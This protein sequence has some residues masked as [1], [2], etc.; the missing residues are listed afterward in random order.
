[1]LITTVNIFLNSMSDVTHTEFYSGG[2]DFVTDMSL[3]TDFNSYLLGFVGSRYFSPSVVFEGSDCHQF[4]L[5][6]KSPISV[7]QRR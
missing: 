1:M 7:F 5:R 3:L 2:V 6:L 4:F